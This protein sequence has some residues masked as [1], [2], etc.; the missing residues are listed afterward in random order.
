TRGAVENAGLFDRFATDWLLLDCELMPWS[1]KALELL[2]EQYAA[3][4]A[5]AGAG[6]G[7]TVAALQSASAAGVDVGP[8]LDRFRERS[9][10]SGRFVDAYRRYCWPIQTIED[11]RL[12][13]FHL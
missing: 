9:E 3:V 12:A 2:R 10:D 5:A 13:Q 6:L 7:E 4:G 1:V 8:L 11:I